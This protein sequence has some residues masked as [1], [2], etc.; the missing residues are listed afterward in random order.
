MR[1]CFAPAMAGANDTRVCHSCVIS[2]LPKWPGQMTQEWA[3]LVSLIC[4][5]KWPGQLTQGWATLASLLCSRNG[6]GKRPKSGP[7]L[8]HCFAPER[9]GQ[10]LVFETSAS[11]QTKFGNSWY[12][13]LQRLQ[14]R[15]C[16]QLVFETS[17]FP[18]LCLQ[19]AGVC[20]L[21]VSKLCL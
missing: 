10:Q 17:T 18:N 12:L 8:C 2:L 20:N 6:R 3:T 21:N 5:R 9:P 7:L 13:K 11:H 4:S 14:K 16:K 19:T 1:H 15:V